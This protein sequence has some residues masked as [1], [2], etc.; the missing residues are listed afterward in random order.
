MPT[1]QSESTGPAL[2]Q[3][4]KQLSAVNA[5]WLERAELTDEERD[6]YGKWGGGA[7]VGFSDSK[8][9]AVRT[10]VCFQDLYRSEAISPEVLAACV[11]S[12]GRVELKLNLSTK[13]P[14]YH[15]NW[16]ANRT[17]EQLAE[18]Q[19]RETE[20]RRQSRQVAKE[21]REG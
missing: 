3:Y 18:T 17:P 21:A 13:D 20:R 15:I 12:A 9:N 4:K 5:K 8:T 11:E 14:R 19:K 7:M 10:D 2:A 16:R 6:A 1:T